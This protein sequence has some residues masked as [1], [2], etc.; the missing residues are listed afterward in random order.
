MNEYA[1]AV[2]DDLQRMILVADNAAGGAS[3]TAE[4]TMIMLSCGT[5]GNQ[6]RVAGPKSMLNKGVV[7][8]T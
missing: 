5:G 8:T 4:G 1:Q 3:P 6:A 2:E 7:R